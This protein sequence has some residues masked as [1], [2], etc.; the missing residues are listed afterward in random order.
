ML[1]T[2]TN[3][4]GNTK[5]FSFTRSWSYSTTSARRC[6]SIVTTDLELAHSTSSCASGLRVR[7]AGVLLLLSHLRSALL[8]GKTLLSLILLT[9]ILGKDLRGL[10]LKRKKKHLL[11]GALRIQKR[12]KAT[13]LITDGVRGHNTNI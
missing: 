4:W 1:I 8:G 3:F 11:I 9:H 5:Y 10:G 13:E 2:F 7:K 12:I 6:H